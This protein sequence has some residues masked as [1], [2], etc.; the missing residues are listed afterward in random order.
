M[1]GNSYYNKIEEQE[2]NYHDFVQRFLF[3]L[4]KIKENNKSV[5]TAVVNFNKT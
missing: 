1:I 2:D 3:L 5:H 4:N